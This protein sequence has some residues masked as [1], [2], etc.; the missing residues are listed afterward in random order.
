MSPAAMSALMHRAQDRQ[1]DLVRQ[2]TGQTEADSESINDNIDHR[3]NRL[4]AY[5]QRMIQATLGKNVLSKRQEQL[6]QKF[7]QQ[8][9][10]PRAI[11][12]EGNEEQASAIKASV[13]DEE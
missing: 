11:D 6:Q 4:E 10:G 3:M 13:T 12:F 1:Q 5:M 7:I 8:R 2:K 9:K